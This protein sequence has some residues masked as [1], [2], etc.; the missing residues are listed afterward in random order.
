MN[1]RNALRARHFFP[2]APRRQA[3]SQAVKYAKA[4]EFLGDKWLIIKKSARLPEMR[5]V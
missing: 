5:P 1:I 2:N 3:A 4:I